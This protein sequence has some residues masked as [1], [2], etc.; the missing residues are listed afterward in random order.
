ML[1]EFI[2]RP[3]TMGE[4]LSGHWLAR[5]PNFMPLMVVYVARDNRLYVGKCGWLICS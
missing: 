1:I 3:A 5:A 4:R 2:D